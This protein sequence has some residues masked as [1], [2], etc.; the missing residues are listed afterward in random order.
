MGEYGATGSTSLA[1]A[2]LLVE[3]AL[4]VTLVVGMILVRRGH[5]RWHRRIQSA[6]VLGNVPIV[7]AWMLPP[8]LGTVW[9]GIPEHLAEPFYLFPTL[10]LIAG[11]AVESLGVYVILVA[12][13]NLLP[14]RLRFRRY[15]LWMRTL[16]GL[17]WLVLVL[18]IS[19]YYFWFVNVS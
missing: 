5:V 17:W 4:A 6:V 2:V 8:Y 10:M 14:E 3:L 1:T 9:P 18:G 15:K 11:A 16:L 12:G 19:T 13:T 7:A